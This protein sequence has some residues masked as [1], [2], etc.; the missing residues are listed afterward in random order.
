MKRLLRRSSSHKTTCIL[1]CLVAGLTFTVA[2]ANCALTQTQSRPNVGALLQ[3][4]PSA[5]DT[6]RGVIMDELDQDQST[7]RNCS[8]S[9]HSPRSGRSPRSVE[10]LGRSGSIPRRCRPGYSR[11]AGTTNEPR[12][13]RNVAATTR[14][15]RR[16]CRKELLNAIDIACRTWQPPRKIVRLCRTMGASDCNKN[17]N[18]SSASLIGPGRRSRRQVLPVLMISTGCYKA[19]TRVTRELHRTAWRTRRRGVTKKLRPGCFASSAKH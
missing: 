12:L 6:E 15:V 4:L 10:A 2:F 8:R 13:P 18:A 17:R 19:T 3:R 16:S 5:D 14:R 11:P 1:F 9:A 7:W